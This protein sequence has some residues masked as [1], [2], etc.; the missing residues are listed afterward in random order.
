MASA[1]TGKI[2]QIQAPELKALNVPS[3]LGK[4]PAGQPKY[5]RTVQTKSGDDIVLGDPDITRGLVAL[6]DQHA[7]DGGA[8]GRE[9]S[10]PPA[11]G[12]EVH[13]SLLARRVL[14]QEVD[15]GD[16]RAA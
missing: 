4:A 8:A 15:I 11:V 2:T 10:Q 9:V 16:G 5:G 13:L 1:D 14:V 7:V 3:K 12:G 6:M